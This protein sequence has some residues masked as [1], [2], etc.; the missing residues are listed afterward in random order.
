MPASWLCSLILSHLLSLGS[1]D[2]SHNAPT[3]VSVS[4]LVDESPYLVTLGHALQVMS[5]TSV[6]NSDWFAL[7]TSCQYILNGVAQ[8]YSQS[9]T[10]CPI[11]QI[12]ELLRR[13]DLFG[14]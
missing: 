7:T 8:W 13:P 4:M 11:S 3:F 6:M 2:R 14:A 9:S 5:H 10:H 1:S 12:Y